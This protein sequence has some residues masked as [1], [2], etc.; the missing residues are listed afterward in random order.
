MS[1]Q[2]TIKP[3]K[4]GPYLVT[5]CETLKG[6][7]DDRRYDS[8]GTVALCRCGGS[9]NKPLCDGTHAQNG[10][11]DEK[12]DDRAPDTRQSYEGGG[13]T[14][15]DNRG[16]CAHAARCT[17]GLP[18]VFRAG[19]EPFV[20]ASAASADEI[21]A[22][23]EQCPSGAL[24]YSVDGTEHRDRESD[25]E[26]LIVPNGPYAVRGGADLEAE[27]GEGAS[28]EHFTLCRCGHSKNKPFCNGAHW[29]HHF[30]E[31]ASET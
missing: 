30:D 6:M 26:I 9:K 28:R 5:H 31:N 23:I 8:A 29:N 13:I 25:P 19:K 18:D 7:V 12:G 3:T 22:T 16:I 1:E 14:I 15:H 24:S 4:N 11:T 2:T 17:N 27:W 20:D 21:Q 10:F